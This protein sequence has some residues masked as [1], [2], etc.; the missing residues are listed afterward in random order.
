M[1]YSI[2]QG[3]FVATQWEEVTDTM[4]NYYGANNVREIRLLP[5]SIC[6]WTKHMAYKCESIK[7]DL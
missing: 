6:D 4:L 5:F 3:F 7:I 1:T 2:P